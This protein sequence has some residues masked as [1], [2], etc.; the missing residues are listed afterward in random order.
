MRDIFRIASF[1][2][3]C[4]ILASPLDAQQHVPLTDE[5]IHELISHELQDEDLANGRLEV[6]VDSRIVTLRGTVPSYWAKQ[7]AIELALDVPD[8]EGVEDELDIA[9]AESDEDLTDEI[10]KRVLRYAFFTIYDDVNVEVKD[11]AVTL[12]GRVTMPYKSKEIAQMTSRILGVQDVRNEIRTLSMSLHDRDVRIAVA[13]RIYRDSMF[14]EY[15]FRVNPPIHI[16]VEGGNV[17]LT[18]I[19]R[20]EVER[21]K[22]EHIARSTFGVFKVENKLKLTS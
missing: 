10:A 11:G 3:A 12:T 6:Q 5:R 17:T 4:A 9:R 7:K 16:I 18:G 21:R 8:V 2:V 14:Y 13:R 19:V 20:S 1:G 15:A 22:A